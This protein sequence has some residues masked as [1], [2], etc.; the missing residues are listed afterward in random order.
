[1]WRLVRQGNERASGSSTR[2]DKYRTY[3][4][5]LENGHRSITIEAQADGADNPLQV[6]ALAWPCSLPQSYAGLS[7]YNDRHKNFY[8][9]S[10]LLEHALNADDHTQSIPDWRLRQIIIAEIR[11]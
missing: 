7:I 4:G 2:I 1:M 9:D 10:Q 8:T 11:N 5:Q 3:C 6:E